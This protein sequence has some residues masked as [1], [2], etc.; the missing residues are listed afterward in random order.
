[1]MS[2][3]K[4]LTRELAEEL[5]TLDMMVSSLVEVLEKKGVLTQEDWER[6][7]KLNIEKSMGKKKYRDI[8]F[9]KKR[10]S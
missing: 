1:M 10:S 8:Q 5:D 2:K 9:S 4:D 3:K 7:I 6:Q